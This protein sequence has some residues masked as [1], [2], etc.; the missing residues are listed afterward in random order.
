MSS[1]CFTT[2][3][4]PRVRVTRLTS[5]G[6]PDTGDCASVTTNG[7][8]SIAQTSQYEDRVEHLTKNG[9]GDFCVE[10]TTAPVLKWYNL[11]LTFCNVDPELVNILS[12]EPLVYDDAEAPTAIGFRN[13][14]GAVANVNFALEGWTRIAGALSCVTQKYGYVL[15]PWIVEGTMGDVTYENAAAT[16]TINARTRRQSPWGVGPYNVNR[17]KATA[18]LDFP[19]PLISAIGELEHRD[20]HITELPPPPSACG[21]TDIPPATLGLSATLLVVTAT[22]PD[23]TDT[24]PA[25]ISWGDGT[26]T[27]VTSGT[28]VNHTYG[29]AGT[30]TVSYAPKEY[31]SAP[32]TA[33][34]T[35]SAT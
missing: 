16:F 7:I 6:V 20:M 31:S 19:L 10:E 21:C 13:S 22:F 15:Y 24:L 33:S 30:K 34:I 9:D 2:F 11:V 14:K 8:I 32:W 35:I 4:L 18:T 1:S 17:S 28:T 26:Y 5:C 12:A 3:K 25:V 29:T 23:P 27:T